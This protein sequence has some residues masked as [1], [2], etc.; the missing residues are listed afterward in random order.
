MASAS[1]RPFTIFADGKKGIFPPGFD[2]RAA[3]AAF[4]GD[5]ARAPKS[6]LAMLADF[7]CELLGIF[8]VK[9][10]TSVTTA[11]QGTVL[12]KA[13]LPAKLR[14]QLQT[15]SKTFSVLRHLSEPF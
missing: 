9:A 10:G 13:V 5:S 11:N 8:S 4:D 15:L 6:S 2:V 14:S 1:A 3:V 7:H 12:F